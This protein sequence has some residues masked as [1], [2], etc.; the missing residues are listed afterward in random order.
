MKNII[1]KIKEIVK[2]ESRNEESDFYCHISVV[3][4][5]A[6]SLAKKYKVKDLE[7]IEIAA[8]LHDIGRLPYIEKGYKKKEDEHHLLGAVKAEKIL[9]KFGYPA[10]KISKVKGMILSH[11]SIEEPRPKTIE[12][13]IISNA[14]AMAVFDVLPIFFYW[15]AKRYSFEDI[16]DWLEAKY[17]RSY[18]NKI[19]LPE[20]KRMVK[21]KYLRNIGMLKEIKELYK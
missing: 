13:K 3:V 16:I 15:R 11:R 18:K 20:A 14:D 7:I 10:E 9:K 19:T 6:K 17:E 5:N 2:K 1:G 4:K 12:E 8:W 21:D